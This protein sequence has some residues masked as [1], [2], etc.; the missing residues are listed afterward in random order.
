MKILTISSRRLGEHGAREAFHRVSDGDTA[1]GKVH[2]GQIS[3]QHV[4]FV[5]LQRFFAWVDV[6]P[7]VVLTVIVEPDVIRSAV[8][9]PIGG[10][11]NP[12][13]VVENAGK[14]GGWTDG[15]SDEGHVFVEE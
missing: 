9:V 10:A 8:A 2:A 13:N 12:G 1:V 5:V 14:K 15:G 3:V 7:V 6:D 4:E 11:E